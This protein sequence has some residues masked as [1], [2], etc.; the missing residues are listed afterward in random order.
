M[1]MGLALSGQCLY[2]AV[3]YDTRTAHRL[4]HNYN[5]LFKPRGPCYNTLFKPGALVTTAGCW[6]QGQP[7][8]AVEKKTVR[9]TVDSACKL[10]LL[11][12]VE[13]LH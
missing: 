12:L 10:T 9:T 13:Q 1:Q 7:K 5:T 8:Q 4:S 2:H 11:L 3:S 6:G